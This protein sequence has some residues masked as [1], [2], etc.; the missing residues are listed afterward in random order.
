M[1]AHAIPFEELYRT[2]YARIYRRVYRLVRQHEQAEGLTQ[3]AFLNAWRAWPPASNAN[4]TGWLYTI[5][6]H[7]ALDALVHER[8]LSFQSLDA[9]AGWL[10]ETASPVQEDNL[11][12]ER[13]VLSLALRQLPAHTRTL[14]LLSAQGYSATELA[15][16]Q[17][18]HK[19]SLARQLASA[20]AEFSRRMTEGQA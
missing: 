12:L 3:A 10:E 8:R 13:L 15:R 9:L 4:L 5:D 19:A 20:R 1:S 18:L 16:V 17:G 11:C 6:T 7:V 2:H 14:L